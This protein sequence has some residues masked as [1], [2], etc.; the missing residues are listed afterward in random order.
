MDKTQDPELAFLQFDT[1]YIVTP[2]HAAII[3]ALEESIRISRRS[4]SSDTI[5]LVITGDTGMGKTFTLKRFRDRL[6]R[7]AQLNNPDAMPVLYVNTPEDATPKAMSTAL[8][9]AL[10]AEF[11]GRDPHYKQMERVRKLMLEK[12]VILIIL[13][14]FQ[15]VFDG[16]SKDESKLV[17]QFIKNFVNKS[18]CP[19]ALAGMRNIEEFIRSS[20]ELRR[21]FISRRRINRYRLAALDTD[22]FLSFLEAVEAALPLPLE[23][24]LTS[25]RMRIALYCISGGIPDYIMKPIK[26]A[27]SRALDRQQGCLTNQDLIDAVEA[28]LDPDGQ[29]INPF[30]QDLPQLH[31]VVRMLH[32]VE[33]DPLR[34]LEPEFAPVRFPWLDDI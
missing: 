18:E 30:E 22:E 20:G 17:A 26:L 5:N 15:H 2:R 25:E 19:I 12:G 10:G 27:L 3:A 7:E 1:L 31:R 4:A 28:M 24:S 34:R 14:E 29:V 16:R 13:D 8:L 21:R 6:N 11:A 23:E 9:E 32:S 33:E